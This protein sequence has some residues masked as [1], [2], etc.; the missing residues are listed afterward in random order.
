MLFRSKQ[1]SQLTSGEGNV[2]QLLRI[3][4]ATRT[5]YYQGVGKEAG[6]DPYFR[7]FYR[8]A[9]DG[10]PQRLLTPEDAD[11]EVTLS[12][13]GKYFVDNF[14]TPDTPSTS[15]L[16]DDTGKLVMQ[17]EKM[18]ISRL[19]AT[20]WKPP[21]RITVKDRGGVGDLYGLM[22][23][24]TNFDPSKKYP[25]INNIYPGPQTGSV[26]S[27]QFSASQIGRAHV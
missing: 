19:V 12:P 20:G 1:K 4:E 18:D 22:F 9:M 2:T 11:H 23:R 3:D 17:L 10:K 13:S 7:H 24:P 8:Q 25:I 6:R 26:G 15:V 14:S 27:R 5:M 16:R 21:M